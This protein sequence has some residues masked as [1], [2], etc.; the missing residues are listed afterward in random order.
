MIP[1]SWSFAAVTGSDAPQ[2]LDGQRVE[3]RELAVGWH[4]EQTVGFGDTARDLGEELGAGHPDRDR[5]P[6]PFEHVAP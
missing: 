4:H 6:D 2:P 3:E 1:R 5:E